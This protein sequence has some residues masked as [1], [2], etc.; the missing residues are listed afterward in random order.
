M[1]THHFDIFVYRWRKCRCRVLNEVFQN[2]GILH[3]TDE[4]YLRKSDYLHSIIEIAEEYYDQN[5]YAAA[6]LDVNKRDKQ[7]RRR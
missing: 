4:D 5:K 1:L 3:W 7:Q 2:L 6:L